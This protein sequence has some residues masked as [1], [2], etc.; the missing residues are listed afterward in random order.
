MKQEF[1][2]NFKFWG[3]QAQKTVLMM[4]AFGVGY[5][6][7][8]NKI[9]GQDV[10]YMILM[11]VVC[12]FV[13]PVSTLGAYLPML[14]SFGSRRTESALGIQIMHILMIVEMLVANY[15][16]R[17]FFREYEMLGENTMLKLLFLMLL[18]TALGQLTSCVSLKFGMKVT[19]VFIVL[20]SVLAVGGMIAGILS[21]FYGVAFFV[22]SNSLMPIATVAAIVLYLI[23]I[24]VLVLV[25]KKF[26]VKNVG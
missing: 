26:E 25:M 12:C 16:H 2:R 5:T 8:F 23:S 14:I 1:I 7:L 13:M 24:W 19:V 6:I 10:N 20:C 9:M 21:G 17:L 15:V 18:C 11:S 4:I 22:L 3:I